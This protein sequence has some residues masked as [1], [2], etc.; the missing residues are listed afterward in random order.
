MQDK[1]KIAILAKKTIKYIEKNI[2]NIPNSHIVL[3]QRILNSL[4]DILENIYRANINQEV[5]VKKEIIVQIQML[6][7]YLK[8]CL[9]KELISKKKFL[10]YSSHLLELH[11][12][13]ISWFK[14]EESE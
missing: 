3:K 2:D 4:Y 13:V 11:T 5:N 14:Y 9:D 1:L 12:M 6:N 8:E 10:S 7:F